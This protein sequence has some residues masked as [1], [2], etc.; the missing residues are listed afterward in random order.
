MRWIKLVAALIALSL[1]SSGIAKIQQPSRKYG[2]IDS[3]GRIVVPA[4]LGNAE[5][6]RD[7]RWAVV[8]TGDWTA[9]GKY[10]F[11]DLHTGHFIPPR[12]EGGLDSASGSGSNSLIPAFAKNLEPVQIGKLW[13]YIDRRARIVIPPRFERA[14]RFAANGLAAAQAGGKSGYIDRKG[15]FVIEPRFKLARDF[16]PEGCASVWIGGDWTAIDQRGLPLASC[17]FVHG[18]T[19]PPGVSLRFIKVAKDRSEWRTVDPRTG[20]A[21]GAFPGMWLVQANSNG[22]ILFQ[23]PAPH[24]YGFVAPDG[25]VAVPAIYD[26]LG[27]FGSNGLAPFAS[28]SKSGF[29]NQTGRIVIAPA[30][31]EALEFGPNGLAPVK[32]GN[33]WG[34]IDGSGSFAIPPRFAEARPFSANGLAAAKQG[35][36]WGF[37]RRS[38]AFAIP[39]HFD[40]VDDFGDRQLARFEFHPK[41]VTLASRRFGRWMVEATIFPRS[42]Y[43]LG[44]PEPDGEVK[45]RL[46]SA[47]G[48][49]E[50]D[51]STQGWVVSFATTAG[52]PP[53]TLMFGNMPDFPADQPAQT[54]LSSLSAQLQEGKLKRLGLQDSAP[55]YLAELQSTRSDFEAGLEAMQQHSREIFGKLTGPPCM[56]PECLY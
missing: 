35:E 6:V 53:S 42:N 11:V 14:S 4:T 56:P 36:K 7:A 27:K 25:R 37:I 54:L 40:A 39:P 3:R 38:G 12:F 1:A 2:Y 8:Q 26:R 47:D 29:L 41:P 21:I 10:G 20:R 52:R 50:W 33:L 34:Y 44:P 49:V 24:G 17:D 30:Y 23:S 45:M 48:L 46:R 15:R 28:G 13:G 9:P 43:S 51:V 16:R 22:L 19:K 18:H 5:A 32:V 31:D 55:R